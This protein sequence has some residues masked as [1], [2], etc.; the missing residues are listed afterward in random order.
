MNDSKKEIKIA[1]E[2]F[3]WTSDESSLIGTHCKSCGN[4]FFPKTFTCHN[5][6]CKDKEVENV[7]LSTKGTIWSYTVL[8]YPPPP[9]FVAPEPFVPIPLAAVEIPEGLKIMGVV[10][11]CKQE[12]LKIGMEVELFVGKLY[13]DN[14]GNDIIGWKFRPA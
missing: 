5:P 14:E 4:Y 11:G 9:P 13:T 10:E 3:N 1:E 6:E 2:L 12:D 8:R 7:T